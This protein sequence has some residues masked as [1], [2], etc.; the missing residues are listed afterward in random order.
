MKMNEDKQDIWA[1][2]RF[3]VG[4]WEGSS[5]KSKTERDYEFILEGKFLRVHNNPHSSQLKRIKRAR[6][7]KIQ[8][9]SATTTVERFSSCD[10]S[11]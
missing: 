11:T 4:S 5:S 2:L 1:P 9:I 8:A 7:M 3:F 10:N 6:F